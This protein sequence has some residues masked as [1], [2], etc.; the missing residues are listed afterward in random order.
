MRRENDKIKNTPSVGYPK[1]Y[2]NT[3]RRYEPDSLKSIIG[4]SGKTYIGIPRTERVVER[5]EDANIIEYWTAQTNGE[6]LQTDVEGKI[7]WLLY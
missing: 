6:K 4:G 1:R 2:G 5:F 3:H 7:P